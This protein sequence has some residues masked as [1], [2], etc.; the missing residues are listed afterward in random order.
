[1]G[2]QTA[3]GQFDTPARK[4]T[5]R[6]QIH[7]KGRMNLAAFCFAASTNTQYFVD[8]ARRANSPASSGDLKIPRGNVTGL[9][10]VSPVILCVRVLRGKV[11][12]RRLIYVSI[13]SR[14][15]A[16]RYCAVRLVL[17]SKTLFHVLVNCVII[18]A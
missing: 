17:T 12:M 14:G 6:C 2:I 11:K 3:K 8:A 7:R 5:K 13:F 15:L 10:E 4:I 1:V 16:M 9:I 18:V